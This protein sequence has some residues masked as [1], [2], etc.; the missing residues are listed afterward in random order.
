MERGEERGRARGGERES[1]ADHGGQTR[2]G[3]GS[4]RRDVVTHPCTTGPPHTEAR[5]RFRLGW[6]QH[7]PP[8]LR[9]G[10][11]SAV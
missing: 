5:I 3:K 7:R 2:C 1:R 8:S 10:F 9:R 4:A 6:M 11:W